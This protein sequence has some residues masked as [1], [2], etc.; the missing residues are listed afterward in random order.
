MNLLMKKWFEGFD[1]FDMMDAMK[2]IED[3]KTK[4]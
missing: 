1:E 4:S 3:A 2:V